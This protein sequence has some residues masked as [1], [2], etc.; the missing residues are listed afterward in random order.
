[1]LISDSTSGQFTSDTGTSHSEASRP[2]TRPMSTLDKFLDSS[3]VVKFLPHSERKR[4]VEELGRIEAREQQDDEVVDLEP[5]PVRK[6]H[7]GERVG[8]ED[9]V[10]MARSS[11]D[12]PLLDRR[13]D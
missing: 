4:D 8:S 1:M 13:R 11:S 2:P 12:Q 9:V 7:G 6:D 3:P 5:L 10:R